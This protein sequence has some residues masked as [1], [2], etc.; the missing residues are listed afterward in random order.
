MRMWKV[1][2]RLLCNKH[3]LGEHVEMHMFAG[4][5]DRGR[6]LGGYSELCE[7]ELI[8][9]RH[10]MLAVELRHRGF[11]HNSPMNFSYEGG[12]TGH[13]DTDRSLNDLKIRCADCRRRI[14]HW[15]ATR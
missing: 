9:S 1:D 3:L 6:R 2:P 11:N 5:F 4:H 12:E 7:P 15:E 14:E 8:V 13:V 10:D